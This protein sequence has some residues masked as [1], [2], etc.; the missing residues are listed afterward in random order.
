MTSERLPQKHWD[1]NLKCF[2]QK[3]RNKRDRGG[4]RGQRERAKEEKKGEEEEE[5]RERKRNDE[6]L[7]D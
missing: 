7:R 5:G 4:E 6:Y 3:S 1:G 2:I